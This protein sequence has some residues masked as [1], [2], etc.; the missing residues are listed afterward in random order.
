MSPVASDRSP[1]GDRGP[2]RDPEH[3]LYERYLG[4]ER[5]LPALSIYY[6]IK[7]LVPRPLQLALRRRYARKQ[8]KRTFPAWPIEPI[9][10]EHQHA[11]FRSR[12]RASESDAVPF[13]NFWPEGRRFAC[14]LT[15]DVEG[16]A[17]VANI[18]R[19]LQVEQRHGFVSAFNFVGEGY[20]IPTGIFDDLRAA[21]CEVGLHGIRHDGRLFQSRSRFEADLPVIGRYLEEWD[22]DGFR[23]PSTMRNADWMHE[24]G[25]LYDSSFPDTDPFEPQ[26]GGCCSIFPFFFGEVVELPITLVQD[27]TLFEILGERSIEYWIHKSEWI[28]RHHGLINLIVHPDYMVDSKRLDLYEQFLR[29]LRSKEGGWTTLPHQVARWWKARASLETHAPERDALPDVVGD[30]F[31]PTVAYAREVDGQVVFST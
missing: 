6:T 7:P 11:E 29:F 3:Y 21:G 19:V 22:V 27:H 26:P 20:T 18:G 23:S 17:G 14:V 15:H 1:T 8:M 2:W 16:P 30:R 5:R 9:L 31:V 4:S 25:C 24:L 13:V 12:L 10:V 28:M